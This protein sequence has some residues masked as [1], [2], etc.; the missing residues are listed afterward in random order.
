MSNNR[1]WLIQRLT[2]TRTQ[3]EELEDAVIALATGQIQSYTL[4]T[5][6]S[7]QTV[8]KLELGTLQNA[9]DKLYTRCTMLEYKIYGGQASYGGPRW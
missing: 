4:D 8:T 7:R 5:N 2:A 9:I 3:I 1:D 6:Q